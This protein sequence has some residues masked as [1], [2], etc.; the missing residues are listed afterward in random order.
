MKMMKRIC[1]I[2][3]L[4]L[5]SACQSNPN[6]PAPEA[7][8]PAKPALQFVDLPGFDKD[9]TSSLGAQLPQ[10]Q[11]SFYDRITPSALPERLQ[12][13]MASVEASGGNV[14]IVPPPSTVTAR[15]PFMLLSAATSLWTA[16]KMVKEAAVT[17][18][19]KNAHPYDA[20]IVLKNDD[21][22]DTV[23]EQVVFSQRK[24]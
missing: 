4:A 16:N 18:Q 11:I 5:L 22:G 13:W 10:V 2:A 8:A 17:A 14:K 20:Q 19:Y 12:R 7:A 3:L 6:A 21:K 15:N 1:V 24:K 23:V 9:M